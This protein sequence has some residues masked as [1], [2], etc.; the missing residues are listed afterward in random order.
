MSWWSKLNSR[1][2]TTKVVGTPETIAAYVLKDIHAVKLEIKKLNELT[3]MLNANGVFSK[4]YRLLEQDHDLQYEALRRS[5]GYSKSPQFYRQLVP[6]YR[7][8]LAELDNL[9]S[10]FNNNYRT[11]LCRERRALRATPD[12]ASRSL[13]VSAVSRALLDLSDDAPESLIDPILFNLFA[14]PVIAPSGITYERS[15]LLE[16]MSRQ[17]EFDPLTRDPLKQGQLYPNLAVKE[18]VAEYV[19]RGRGSRQAEGGASNI[20]T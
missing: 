15:I 6:L 12:A 19:G 5:C 9:L 2:T 18:Q 10:I 1:P 20:Q 11:A 16:H 7:Q 14:D 8:Q 3:G 13:S 4:L 17:G